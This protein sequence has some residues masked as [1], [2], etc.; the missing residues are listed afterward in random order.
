MIICTCARLSRTLPSAGPRFLANSRGIRIACADDPPETKLLH[1]FVLYSV[2][3]HAPFLHVWPSIYAYNLYCIY[4]VHVVLRTRVF[5]ENWMLRFF[6]ANRATYTSFWLLLFLP[7]YFS[8][9]CVPCFV[10][11]HLSVF[12]LFYFL[13]QDLCIVNYL[14]EVIS[15]ATAFFFQAYR[16]EALFN[17]F[18]VIWFA[19]HVPELSN[20]CPPP[21]SYVPR[22]LTF[23]SLPPFIGLLGFSKS[24]C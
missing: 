24:S 7:T 4:E 11:H 2:R 14:S 20:I 12:F 19:F 21:W 10:S 16:F 5:R 13:P 8:F 6:Y 17:L 22:N 3:G 1:L 15:V 9:F 23:F 18:Q